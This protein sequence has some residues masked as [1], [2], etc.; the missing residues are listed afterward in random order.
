MAPWGEITVT[1]SPGTTPRLRASSRPSRSAGLAAGLQQ[2]VEAAEPELARERPADRRRGEVH[3]AEKAAGCA[4][5]LRREQRLLQDEGSRR[6]HALDGIEPGGKPR[7]VG[8]AAAA[9]LHDEDVRVGGDDLVADA[10]LKARHDREHDDQRAHAEEDA[11]HADPDEEGEIGAVTARSEVAETQEQL[12]G[13]AASASSR[14]VVAA[15]P[16][17]RSGRRR[18]NRITSRIDG[19][20]VKSMVSRSI[21]IPSP[22]VGGIPYSRART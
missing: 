22:A 3:A 15:P 10:V 19:E 13:E 12:E 9:R 4:A 16:A 20:S 17:P 18:G 6:P 11:P 7:G 1:N 8:D 2:W 14:L 21:P 5:A